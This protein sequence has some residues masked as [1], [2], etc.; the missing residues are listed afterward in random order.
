MATGGWGR[1]AGRDWGTGGSIAESGGPLTE[2]LTV[3][4]S[5]DVDLPF[6]LDGAVAPSSFRVEATFS[7]AVDP[8]EGLNPSNYSIPGLTVLGVAAHLTDPATVVLTTSEQLSIL[9][10]LTVTPVVVESTAGDPLVSGQNTAAFTG[11]GIAPSFQPAAMATRKVEIIFSEPMLENADLISP[12]NY[13]VKSV[14]GATIPISSVVESGPSPIQRVTLTLGADLQPNNHYAA[15]VDAAIKSA[16]WGVS[17]YPNTV[18]FSWIPG[19]SQISIGMS[20]FS[21]EVS[22][23]LLGQ[24]LGQ[25]YFS[26]ALETAI[27]NSSVEVDEVS[28]CTRAWDQYTF[29]ELP[30][31]PILYTFS[32]GETSVIGNVLWAPAERLGLAQVILHDLRQETMPAAVDGPADATLVETIDITRASFLNDVRWKLY[33][34]GG[35]TVFS[36]ADNLT[37]IGPGPTTN[38]NLQP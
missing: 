9:Y 38:I 33:D 5:L 28:L 34:G 32:V 37:P 25:I 22:G 36:T 19:T 23:G 15:T 6:V 1:G 26:P 12:A 7:Y 11:Y 24:P 30:D 10:T 16:A 29:P 2:Y 27:A 35:A 31:P 17:V 18:L 20:R 21:G 8:T 4:E 13:T 14:S 3:G